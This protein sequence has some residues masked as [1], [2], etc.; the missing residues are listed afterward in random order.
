MAFFRAHSFGSGAGI[1]FGG[2]GASVERGGEI[3]RKRIEG[4]TARGRESSSSVSKLDDDAFDEGR[5]HVGLLLDGHGVLSPP[6]RGGASA[7]RRAA[8]GSEGSGN[9]VELADHA[10]EAKRERKEDVRHSPNE[11]LEARTFVPLDGDPKRH[12]ENDGDVKADDGIADDPALNAGV[13]GAGQ[14]KKPTLEVEV[15]AA[16]DAEDADGQGE[17]VGSA[18]STP[19]A[20][21]STGISGEASTA[22]VGAGGVISERTRAADRLSL[23]RWRNFRKP[24]VRRRCEAG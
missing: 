3:S 18:S 5:G 7:K 15:P 20:G 16:S 14:R 21:R 19:T 2:G 10:R 9:T 8:T 12:W 11:P 4:A 23:R 13:D 1:A 17:H 22:G 24:K 6:S